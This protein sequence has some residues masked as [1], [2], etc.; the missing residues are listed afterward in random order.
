MVAAIRGEHVR[1]AGCG[2]RA[3]VIQALA[4]QALVARLIA[5]VQAA[6]PLAFALAIAIAVA[7]AKAMHKQAIAIAEEV[8]QLVEI[9]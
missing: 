3:Y 1:L 2:S 7:K 4:S 8:E 9:A 6:W 5:M